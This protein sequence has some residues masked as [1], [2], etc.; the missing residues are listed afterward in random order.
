M[1]NKQSFK[2]YLAF[3][4]WAK[5]QSVDVGRCSYAGGRSDDQSW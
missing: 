3:K 4:F 5:L 2:V 1:M